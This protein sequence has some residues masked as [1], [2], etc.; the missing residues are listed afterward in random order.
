MTSRVIGLVA[1]ITLALFGRTLLASEV[2]ELNNDGVV[3]YEQPCYVKSL[4]QVVVIRDVT[5][6]CEITDNRIMCTSDNEP[7]WCEE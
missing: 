2:I 7:T 6:W 5:T 4:T 3:P 1:I